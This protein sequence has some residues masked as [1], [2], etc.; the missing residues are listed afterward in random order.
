MTTVGPNFGTASDFGAGNPGGSFTTGG[1]SWTNPTNA[2]ATDGVFATSAVNSTTSNMLKVVGFGFNIPNGATITGITMI[3]TGKLSSVIH[4]GTDVF[5]LLK[6]G[7]P[8][9]TAKSNTP[10]IATTTNTAYTE[11]SASDLWGTTWTPTDINN[12]NFGVGYQCQN[13]GGSETM[14]IDSITITIDYTGGGGVQTTTISGPLIMLL[15]SHA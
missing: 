14:S 15:G 5:Q 8:V 6:A 13:T 1:S 2:D 10:I 7:S 3:V 11:G 12:A 4:D 9:G